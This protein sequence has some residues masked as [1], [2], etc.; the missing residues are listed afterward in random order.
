MTFQRPE[1]IGRHPLSA[2]PFGV[3]DLVRHVWQYT[4]EF[5][6]AHTRS[7]ILRGGSSYGPCTHHA[8]CTISSMTSSFA[9][10]QAT[11][12]GTQQC[13]D[14]LPASVL[15]RAQLTAALLK[16]G[17]NGSS[18]DGVVSSVNNFKTVL[19]WMVTPE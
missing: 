12:S 9:V 13:I 18:L 6:D 19:F 15:S 10:V 14:V 7:V 5:Q 4:S 17:Y 3:E 2:S 16:A 11:I 8:T 1:E